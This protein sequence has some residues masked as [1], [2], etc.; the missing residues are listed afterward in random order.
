MPRRRDC[1]PN[2]LRV[3]AG[4]LI[5]GI[6]LLSLAERLELLDRDYSGDGWPLVVIAVG[7]V[8]LIAPRV[9]RKGR[10]PSRRPAGWLLAVGAWGL[11]NEYKLMGLDYATSWPL[12]VVYAG[13]DM[14]WRA[15]EA[16]DGAVREERTR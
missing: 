10:A 11:I 9:D 14:V 7:V 16:P 15:L 8:V 6:G 12:L 3:F 5:I 13:A 2:V 1:H 4:V